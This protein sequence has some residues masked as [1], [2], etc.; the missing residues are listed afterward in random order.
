MTSRTLIYTAMFGGRDRPRPQTMQIPGCDFLLVTDDPTMVVPH[1]WRVLYA[2]PEHEHPNLAAKWWR[3][4]PPFA[5]HYHHVIWIDANMEI[6]IPSLATQAI[7]A[8]N[9]GIAAWKH[10]R[11]DCIVDEMEASLGAEAQGGR[12]DHLPMREQVQAY[13]DEG[14]PLHNGLYATGTI[15]WTPESAELLGQEWYDECVKWGYQDQIS[16]PVVCWR[17]D[18][19]PGVFP[20]TQAARRVNARSGWW[21]NRWMLLHDHVPGTG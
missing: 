13:L 15:V 2:E 19:K 20:V 4:H 7:A 9:D 3:T 21:A 5:D 6:R 17:H 8:V 14:Y 1:P 10:P 16:F 18:I 12:Y 11:R